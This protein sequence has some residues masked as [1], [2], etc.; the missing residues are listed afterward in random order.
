MRSLL[1]ATTLFLAATAPAAAQRAPTPD[2]AYIDGRLSEMERQIRGL[3]G[4]VER[5]EYR[6]RQ[7]DARVEALETAL[8]EAKAGM[9]TS[10][11]PSGD[12]GE[13]MATTPTRTANPAAADRT[14]GVL[15]EGAP[16]DDYDGAFGLLRGGDFENGEAAFRDFLVKYPDHKLATNARYWIGE[17]LYA[18]QRYQEAAT[19]FLESWKADQRGRKAPDNLLKL[20]MS[21][22]RLEKLEEACI[23]YKKLLAEYRGADG[24]LLTAAKRERQS[25]NCG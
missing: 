8:Q 19:Q 21:L 2:V 22:Q 7:S 1:I 5:L 23:A 11:D 9:A 13:P 20:G 17:S 12:T 18:Q 16:Q 15:P 3:T 10:Q 24:R 14:A 25:L 6:L 4:K